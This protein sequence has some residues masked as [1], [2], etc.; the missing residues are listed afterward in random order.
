MKFAMSTLGA[1]VGS[2]FAAGAVSLRSSP[3]L[4]H[5]SLPAGTSAVANS[6]Y[7]ANFGVGHG[8]AGTDTQSIRVIIP[9]GVTSVRP[10]DNVFGPAVVEKDA[11]GLVTAVSWTRA[12]P[13]QPADT[14]FYRLLM[15]VKLPNTP[16]T[17]VWFKVTQ[18]CRAADGSSSVVQW[19]STDEEPSTHRADAGVSGEPDNAASWVFLVRKRKPGWNRYAVTQRIRDLS[20]FDDATIVWAGTAAYSSNEDTKALITSEPGTTLLTEIPAGT[21]LWV[22]Y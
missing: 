10:V 20:V 21:E 13:V 18:T 2:L 3:A 14:H 19:D 5:P 12:T 6:T 7:E 11:A 22:K 1:V 4:A 16:F 9:A 15:R 17:K 8:C